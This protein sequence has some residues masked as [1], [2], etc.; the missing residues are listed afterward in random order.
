[1]SFILM[2]LKNIVIMFILLMLDLFYIKMQHNDIHES[3][4]C[5]VIA[6]GTQ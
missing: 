2:I 4:F 6:T 5:L 1:M 3:Y